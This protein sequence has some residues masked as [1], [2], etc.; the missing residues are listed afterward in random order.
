MLLVDE[1]LNGFD[2]YVV[3]ECLVLLLVV[4]ELVVL[5]DGCMLVV[6][7]GGLV[8]IV[9]YDIVWFGL[10]E[11]FGCFFDW[12]YVYC[13]GLCEYDMVVVMLCVDD[14]MLLL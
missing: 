3:N 6:W 11:L 7:V 12:I 1:G 9:V 10:V 13:F 14:G 8:W 2:V 5:C 4:V